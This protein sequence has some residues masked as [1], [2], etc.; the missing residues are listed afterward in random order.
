[1]YIPYMLLSDKR[2]TW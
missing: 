1:L 2:T